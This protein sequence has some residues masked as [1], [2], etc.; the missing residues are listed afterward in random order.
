MRKRTIGMRKRT[1]GVLATSVALCALLA[2]VDGA[3]ARGGPH[4]GGG[5]GGG[6]RGGGMHVGGGHMGGGRAGGI[7][8]GGL[9]AGGMRGVGRM[10]GHGLAGRSIGHGNM[11]GLAHNGTGA[12]GLTV[13]GNLGRANVD[14]GLAVHNGL[15]AH[16]DLATH[17]G[18]AA[19]NL[20]AHN[21]RLGGRQF[22]HNQF[23]ARNFRGL[24]NFNRAGF[25]RNAFGNAGGWNRWGGQ[26]WGA[27]WNNWG[28]GWG[29]WAGPVFWPFLYGDLFS[30]AFWPGGYYNPF[31]AF[32]PDFFLASIFAPG[33][34]F[35]SAYGYGP[36]Y[37]GAAGSPNVYYGSAG[38]PANLT[39]ADRQ[40]LAR[41]DAAAAQSCS[42]L[43]PGVNDLPIARI[44]RT[45]H[46]TPE[47]SAL[48]DDVSAASSKAADAVEASCPHDIP[49][50]PV[51]RLD[52][53]EKRLGAMI[54]AAAMVRTPLEKFYVSLSDEQK[55]R[56][57][58]MG[59]A[60]GS[61][62]AADNPQA[63]CGNETG[64]AANLPVQRIEQVVQP[65]AQQQGSFDA[66]KTAAADAAREL[67]TSCP[68]AIPQT[69]VARLDS[70]AARLKAV[71]A[72]MT[73]VRP[74]LESFYASLS[75]E[76]KAKFNTMGPPPSGSAQSAGQN[77]AQ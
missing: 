72:A 42:G 32:G 47:Q 17:D 15:A 77:G 49:L 20:A 30:Y 39:N 8:M 6:G 19:H 68:S 28:Y 66:L 7:H 70:A 36:D 34:Y 16:N 62:A 74:Q 58:A 76:Q 21:G 24:Y 41:T 26:F 71:V 55:R 64:G 31:W 43:A 45:I 27:G 63:L 60:E 4:G 48:L 29:G 2:A 12:R 25:N 9:H 69:P 3:A 73:L 51:A 23:A 38:A 40:A 50:T 5:H 18:P 65:T 46:P 11:R 75:D 10:G 44:E 56:F 14:R 61:A 35:G 59:K 53:A 33:P 54:E 57:D 52:A 13:R 1:I 22:A 67:Q 37:Y